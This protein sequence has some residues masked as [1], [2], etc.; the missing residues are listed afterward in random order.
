[1]IDR[2]F[3]YID[4][5]TVSL[6]VV[7]MVIDGIDENQSLTEG[8]RVWQ[9]PSLLN[10][11][12]S[13]LVKSYNRSTKALRLYNYSGNSFTNFN[14]TLMFTSNSS[15]N[16]NVNT[17]A[18]VTAPDEYPVSTLPN[19]WFYGNGQAK[20]V[21][22]F[23]NGLIKFTGFY[24]NTDGF[25]SSDKK[26]QDDKKY[27]NYSYVIESEKSLSEYE[28][29]MKDIVHPIGMSMLARVISKSDLQESVNSSVIVSTSSGINANATVSVSN[30][31]TA[32]VTGQNT[33]WN[34]QA[35]VGDM[36]SVIDPTSPLRSQ[37]K[38]IVA[39]NS[40]TS[41]NV[42]SNFVYVGQGKLTTNTSNDLVVISANS[43]T[44]GDFLKTG[45]TVRFNTGNSSSPDIEV[46]E[47]LGI[48]GNV[49]SL[50]NTANTTN[51][52]L[53]YFVVPDYTEVPYKISK[54]S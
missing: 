18:T 38:T 40:D 33:F 44:I 32:V 54:V 10:S 19:P 48:S 36:L 47:V 16:F 30:A 31:Y 9:G 45:D 34:T 49:V 8:E 37:M 43:N 4:T 26:L 22:E 39:V 20:A 2:G 12:F 6:K 42:E 17:S 1:M 41:L 21:A 15:V 7:D 52:N 29:T 5:P 25:L 13:G 53:V 35:T 24:I 23:Y 11:V 46:Y 28:S 14:S 50:N 27:H 3:D 51:T